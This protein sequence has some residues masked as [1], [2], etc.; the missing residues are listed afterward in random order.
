M[1]T[2]RILGVVVLLFV[3][4][5]CGKK[6]AETPPPPAQPAPAPAPKPEVAKA[7]ARP[8]CI[9]PVATGGEATLKVGSATWKQNGSTVTLVTPPKKGELVVGL[10]TDIK[11]ATDENQANLKNIAAWF[12]KKGVSFV[13]VAGDT[14]MSA[15]DIAAAL[16]V[17]A[18]TKV[19]VFDIIGN[20]EGV[21][22]YE[23]G[24]AGAREAHPNVFDLDKVRRIDTPVL[25]VVSLPGYFNPKYLHAE[26]GCLYQPADVAALA[27]IVKSCD[28]PVL[29]VSHGPPRQKGALALDRTS[30]GENV[31]DPELARALAELKIPFGL[32]GNIH[33]AGGRATDLAG[34][35]I[36]PQGK[37]VPS[38]YVHPGPADAVEWVMNDGTRSLGM[39]GLLTVKGNKAK[40]EILRLGKPTKTA[41]RGGKHKGK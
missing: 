1:G 28:S 7:P 31:G 32:F 5:G 38:L 4:A 9:G 16:S 15:R 8:S 36:I 29:L 14:G 21:G 12:T 33:E 40:Y 2:S 20:R 26:D 30:E 17:L 25:D 3:L 11:E 34:E 24:T 39:A 13:L 41:A 10:V 22:Y 37:L 35:Q 23:Q 18:A 6:Q 19:P 27:D